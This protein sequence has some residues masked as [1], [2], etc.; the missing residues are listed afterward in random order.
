MENGGGGGGRVKG[1]GGGEM[2][3]SG[4][5]SSSCTSFVRCNAKESDHFISSHGCYVSSDH[6]AH[7]SRSIVNY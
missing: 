3:V 2:E 4:N 1:H 7:V 5:D 6:M